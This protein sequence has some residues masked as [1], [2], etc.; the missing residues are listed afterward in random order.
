MPTGVVLDPNRSSANHV[1][2]AIDQARRAHDAGVRQVWI[3]QQFDHDAISLAGHVGVAVPGLKVG[4]FVVPINPRH[5]LV[6]ASQAQT[7]QAA[8]GGHF[9]LGLGLGAHGP[10]QA[11]FGTVWPNT[12]GRLREHLQ[13]LRSI[14]DTGTV[15]FHGEEFTAA[16]EFPVTVA[17]GAPLPVYVA[18]MG[19]KALRVTGELAD[20][21][22]PY[23]AGPRTVEEFIVPTITAAA[24]AAGRPA[25][26]VIAAV[27][28]LVT[29]DVNEGRARAAEAL[30]FYATIPSYARVIAREGADSVIDLAAVGTAAQVTAQLRRYLDAGAT[31]VVL[32]PLVR[33]GI[34]ALEPIWDVAAAL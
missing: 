16:P 29:D 26:K 27:P 31:D 7:A 12:I 30:G 8:T 20:G 17:G 2:A 9:S 22:L 11:A 13:V 19:P 4:T 24:T 15:N 21:T 18:A 5:P 33:T 28:V 23:L 32:S 25:P 34:A 6:V 3:A 14:L 10:E 1:A